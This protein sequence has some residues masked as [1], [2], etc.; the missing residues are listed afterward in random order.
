MNEELLVLRP[1]LPRARDRVIG[2][3]IWAASWLAADLALSRHSVV[4]SILDS[5]VVGAVWFA[6]G[7]VLARLR[8]RRSLTLEKSKL[9]GPIE[10]DGKQ[11]VV[12]LAALDPVL[13]MQL[14]GQARLPRVVWLGSRAGARIRFIPREFVASERVEFFTAVRERT[15]GS[16]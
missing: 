1:T 4:F 10:L 13:L 11:P 5:A 9:V 12:D 3:A 7:M 6:T 15:A 2:T 16:A 14:T 8:A